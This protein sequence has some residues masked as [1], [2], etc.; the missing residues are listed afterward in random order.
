MSFNIESI[1]F[2]QGFKREKRTGKKVYRNDEMVPVVN[3]GC[4]RQEPAR[5]KGES[6][7]Q[8]KRRVP[9]DS[10]RLRRAPS[11]SGDDPTSPGETWCM[12]NMNRGGEGERVV[13]IV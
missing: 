3:F 7:V 12:A 10:V 9:S 4:L 13:M 2:Q 6:D 1:R 8:T 11:S 5:T